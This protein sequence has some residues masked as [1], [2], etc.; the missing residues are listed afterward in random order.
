MKHKPACL[1][2]LAAFILIGTTSFGE[3]LETISRPDIAATN[4]PAEW[5]VITTLEPDLWADTNPI[6]IDP[7]LDQATTDAF[8]KYFLWIMAQAEH[9]SAIIGLQDPDTLTQS[10]LDTAKAKY[11][12]ST[13]LGMVSAEKDLVVAA[14]HA[15]R[16]SLPKERIRAR[17]F[18]TFEEYDCMKFAQA[19]DHIFRL[20]PQSASFQSGYAE[21]MSTT[22]K[23]CS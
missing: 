8:N 3:D 17:L 13:C 1:A 4:C 11:D 18:Q 5:A 22:I 15:H 7:S 20:D 9:V 14:Y 2:W 19:S 6:G 10:Y 12:L 21:I 23:D 16:P